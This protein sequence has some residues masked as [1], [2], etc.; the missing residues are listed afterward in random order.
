[1]KTEIYDDTNKKIFEGEYEYAEAGRKDGVG[2]PAFFFSLSNREGGIYRNYE[3]HFFC[4]SDE[5]FEGVLSDLREQV[6]R[7]NPEEYKK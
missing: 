6:Y 4:E 1:M 2:A 7:K 5:E 3:V